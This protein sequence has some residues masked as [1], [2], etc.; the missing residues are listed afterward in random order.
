MKTLLKEYCENVTFALAVQQAAVEVGEIHA[1]TVLDQHVE[2]VRAGF[3]AEPGHVI[4]HRPIDALHLLAVQ[5]HL[6]TSHHHDNDNNKNY[7]YFYYYYYCC[8]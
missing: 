3:W 4:R 7:Y 1:T 8:H 6:T 5:Q 2:S